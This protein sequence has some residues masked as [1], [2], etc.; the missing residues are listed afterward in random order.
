MYCRLLFLEAV[1]DEFLDLSFEVIGIACLQGFLQM[2]RRLRFQAR[3][4]IGAAS[5]PPKRPRIV[6][7]HQSSEKPNSAQ[8]E[9][10]TP[11][12]AN[13]NDP[14]QINVGESGPSA[15]P[16]QSSSKSSRSRS[17]LKSPTNTV[18]NTESGAQRRPGKSHIHH[19]SVIRSP[20]R[21]PKP[22]K[23]FT[24]DEPFDPKTMT[25]QDLI[26]WNPKREKGLK[27]ASSER[28]KQD[29]VGGSVT[30]ENNEGAGP[31]ERTAGTANPVAAPQV[32]VAEDGSLI[33]DE[34]SLTVVHEDKNT[35]SW[36]TVNEEDRY[37]RKT[38][39][40]SFRKTAWRKGSPWT[41]LETD[42][43][44]EILSATGPDFGL[45]HEFF[46]SR[47][48]SELK[49][50]FNREERL[51]WNRVNNALKTPALLSEAL[52]VR[53]KE[54]MEEIKKQEAEKKQKKR[55]GKSRKSSSSAQVEWVEDEADLIA[56]A[57]EEIYRLLENDRSDS[58]IAGQSQKDSEVDGGKKKS[59]EAKK[60]TGRSA[61]SS[62]DGGEI[63]KAKKEAI[64]NAKKTV[65]K[66]K[67]KKDR[68]EFNRLKKHCVAGLTA[69]FPKFHMVFDETVNVV[70]VELDRDKQPLVRVPLN[71][72]ARACPEDDKQ[73]E[74]VLLVVPGTDGQ[75]E[76]RYLLRH[77]FQPRTESTGYLHLFGVQ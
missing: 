14:L 55:T 75:P 69:D 27:S 66:E 71:T 16:R 32:K 36:E 31:K 26:R 18:S 28:L 43:F 7:K 11:S 74:S 4:N 24:G 41:A 10:S 22:R 17:P 6:A 2:T 57:E 58:E 5:K 50:K 63:S 56:E 20:D 73:P 29:A 68:S 34:S 72:T 39:S 47:A 65:K 38:T 44:Y 3:P 13:T 70:S 51:N 77:Q 61:G 25:M 76:K 64:E 46:P 21:V 52:H 49:S 48:R 40:M 9:V 1:A 53:A 67:A 35:D 42:L 62:G 15:K 8:D 60:A 23:K 54:I 59:S 37:L 45:M 12:E 19:S 33:L 30:G